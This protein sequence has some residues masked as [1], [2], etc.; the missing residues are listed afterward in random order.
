MKDDDAGFLLW[1]YVMRWT[2]LPCDL[3]VRRQIRG[4]M[5]YLYP[6]HF[7]Y[8]LG[9]TRWGR[10]GYWS[11]RGFYVVNLRIGETRGLQRVCVQV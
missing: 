7:L 5:V 6:G 8:P 2:F 1:D 3:D 4:D 11:C 9:Y 10:I